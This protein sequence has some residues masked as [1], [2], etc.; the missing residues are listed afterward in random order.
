MF[1]NDM[2]LN[3]AY[4][5]IHHEQGQSKGKTFPKSTWSYKGISK[6]LALNLEFALD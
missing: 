4:A 3:G 1:I 2:P 6:R 5:Q